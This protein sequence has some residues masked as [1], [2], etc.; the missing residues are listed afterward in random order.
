MR[1]QKLA[2]ADAVA[3]NDLIVWEI[4]EWEMALPNLQAPTPRTLENLKPS[5]S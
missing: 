5:A 4:N 2:L 1:R 3:F